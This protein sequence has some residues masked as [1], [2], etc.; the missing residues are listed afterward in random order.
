MATLAS[1][2]ILRA[3]QLAQ[4]LDTVHWTEAEWLEWLNDGQLQIVVLRPSANTKTVS[5]PLVA[6]TKQAIPADGVMFL[7]ITRN[8]GVGGATPGPA[9]R[10]VKRRVLDAFNPSWHTATATA[11]VEHFVFE[12]VDSKTFYVYPPATGAAQVELRYS[13]RPTA[14]LNS[15]SAIT[16]DDIYANCL[17]DYMLYRAYSKDTEV[18]ANLDRAALYAKTFEGFLGAKSKADVAAAT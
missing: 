6:G 12:D 7:D 10:R 18:Q 11:V 3:Q 14:V 1:A 2:L 17:L 15:A 16:L 4:D 8:M 9:P 5:A 13:A